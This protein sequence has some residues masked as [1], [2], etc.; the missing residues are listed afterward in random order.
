MNAVG[1]TMTDQDQRPDM[2]AH[3]P[4]TKKLIK[5]LPPKGA[6]TSAYDPALIKFNLDGTFVTTHEHI[7][8]R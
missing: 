4:A 6:P 7:F 2:T 1:E 8:S 3:S 5:N